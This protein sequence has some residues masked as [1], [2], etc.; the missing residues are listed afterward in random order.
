M[1]FTSPFGLIRQ[2]FIILYT[3]MAQQ[4]K[5]PTKTCVY[6][7]FRPNLFHWHLIQLV[8]A[9]EPLNTETVFFTVQIE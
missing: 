9:H 6:T 8:V 1:R 7:C 2:E 3:N 4:K 5:Q